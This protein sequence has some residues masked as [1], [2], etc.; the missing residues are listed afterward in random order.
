MKMARVGILLEQEAAEKRWQY[1][2]NV[3]QQYM[4]EILSHA[5]FP[6]EWIYDSDHISNH[7]Y[8]VIIVALLK[9]DDKVSDKLWNF[10][11]RGG[12]VI[13]YAGLNNLSK[14][15]GW[16]PVAD[17]GTGYAKL[18]E[19][20]GETRP[21]RFL[22]AVPWIKCSESDS[23]YEGLG[24]ILEDHPTGTSLSPALQRFQVGKGVIDRWSVDIINT[25]VGLQQG[26]KPIFEDGFPAPDG[27]SPVNDGILK[28]DDEMQM[29]YNYD[30]V[31][32]EMGAV[33]FAFPYA[34]WW[35]EALITHLL[36]RVV[37]EGLTLPFIGLYPDGVDRVA[38]ISHDSDWSSDEA[39]EYVLDVL[40]AHN[41]HS[42]W[43]LVKPGYGSHIHERIQAEGHEV[44]L[45]YN[46]LA[47]DAGKWSFEDFS[48]Q[49]Q[50]IKEV[51]G[52]ERVSSNKNHYT[53]FEGWGELFQWCEIN[54]IESDQSRGPSKKGN[55]GFIFGTC[56]P[57]FPIAWSDE[58]NRIYNVLEVGFLTQDIPAWTD[59]SVIEPF[60]QE[61]ANVNG[62]AHFLFH[63][64]R[65]HSEAGV[66]E[67]LSKVISRA[68][69][70]G[71]TFWTGAQ[72]N[73]W[74]R[75]RR[76]IKIKD[77]DPS[78]RVKLDNPGNL[79]G[80]VIWVPQ[81]HDAETEGHSL[82]FYGMNCRK[83][84]KVRGEYVSTE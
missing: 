65:I 66:V 62:I 39:G 32:S 23:E 54:D 28:A 71:F 15:L 38:M 49:A 31:K 6:Y 26:S 40:K 7:A 37:E 29:D 73:E 47:M 52:G 18:P 64:E 12:I 81:P 76:K 51:V 84:T 17:T 4:Q 14:R 34:D 19:H 42:T 61:V 20:M 11:G 59:E 8:N 44:A 41:I 2:M 22:N 74:E 33:Y 10:A 58:R 70:Y 83:Q 35:R 63:Q 45:H 56:H 30:R 75:S 48:I 79:E 46:A 67:A 72:I 5:G 43:C 78:G 1:G 21:T 9:E 36:N 82:R 50:W 27:S 53:R 69:A 24:E 25:I 80:Y 68:K 55:V 13:S 77:I 60:L 16:S 57:Y 3:F